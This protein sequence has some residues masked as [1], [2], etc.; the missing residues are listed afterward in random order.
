[1]PEKEGNLAVLKKIVRALRNNILTGLFLVTPIA[2]AVFIVQWLF[3]FITD[4][5]VP[6]VPKTFGEPYPEWMFRLFALVLFLAVLFLFGLL[7]RNIIGARLYRFSDALLSRIPVFNKIYISVRQI[8][9]ALLSQSQTL[10]RKVVLVEYPRKGLY[11]LGFVT[12]EVP[13]KVLRTVTP[14]PAEQDL[15]AVF[16]PTT[17]NPTS[18][19]IILVPRA[20]AYELAMTVGEAMKLVI[21]GAAVYPGEPESLDTRPTFLDKLQAWAEREG[22]L[23]A[24]HGPRSS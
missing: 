16:I 4:R 24:G 15:V 3:T 6:F 20:E 14:P 18:G 23:D 1:M 17:P 13:R 9:E 8:G 11:A 7:A 5:V 12:S 22:R 2:V 10:F 21:S 19:V